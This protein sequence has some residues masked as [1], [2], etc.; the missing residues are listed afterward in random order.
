MPTQ[1]PPSASRQGARVF[2]T[3]RWTVVLQAGGSNS[4]G[5]TAA[6]EKL[7]RAYWYP[8]VRVNRSLSSN[9]TG[10]FPRIRLSGVV[11]DKAI[12]GRTRVLGD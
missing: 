8:L 9:W 3:T 5:G 12:G 2:A 1:D 4:P 6:L 7:C 10:G 11:H